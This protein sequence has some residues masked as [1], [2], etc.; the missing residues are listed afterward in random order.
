MARKT[1]PA[2]QLTNASSLSRDRAADRYTAKHQKRKRRS[3]VKGV[4]I[5]LCVCLAC[6]GVALALYLGGIQARLSSG[7]DSSLLSSL[8]RTTVTEPFYM[9]LLGTDKSA[10][11]EESGMGTSNSD[12]RSDSIILA[13][14]DPTNK[15]V[16]LVS[17]ERD[18]LVDMGD[19]GQQKINAAYSLGGP[20]Y[21]VDVIS[22]FAGVDISHYAEIDFD[23]FVKVVDTIGGIDV[24]IKIDL[25]DDLADLHLKA[26]E[27][28]LDGEQALALCRSRHAYDEY[29]GGDYYRTANQRMVIGAI[30]KKILASNASTIAASVNQLADSV[31]TDLS[32]TDILSLAGSFQGF[33]PSTNLMSGLT[34]TES[35]Y[36]NGG[37]YDIIKEDEWET[38]MERVNAGLSP[39]AS[40]DDDFTS[41][42]AGGTS[43]IKNED[44]SGSDSSS[45]S[46]SSTSTTEKGNVLVMNGAGVNGLAG[47]VATSLRS[48]GYTCEAVSAD[49]FDHATTEVLAVGTGN[50][51]MAVSVAD[52][53]GLSVTGILDSA[54]SGTPEGFSPAVVVVL[55][56]DMVGKF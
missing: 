47:S 40:A 11:R 34:P 35:K 18:I 5:T 22:D 4:L 52:Q 14:I 23:E 32:L 37:W 51:G 17:I 29:G 10:E 27:Q 31:T 2:R 3:I 33:D 55:G 13:R 8:S 7:V 39:Y 20:S 1:K 46:E 56:Q 15:E 44:S 12:Y 43:A 30:L 48:A 41:E 53:L 28:T 50:S 6:G 21:A 42:V 9:L 24:D 49:S 36:I 26:G 19:Y 45:S 54:P 38:M 16:T 25:D